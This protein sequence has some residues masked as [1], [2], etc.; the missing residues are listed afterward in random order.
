MCGIT[1]I[2]NYNLDPFVLRERALKMS[3]LL[4]H[5]GPDDAGIWSGPAV[6]LAHRRLSLLDT[7][8]GGQPM[9]SFNRRYSIVYNGEVYNFRE[10]RQE[11]GGFFETD[12]D[13]EVILRA[14]EKWGVSCLSR[15]NGMFSFFIWDSQ[16]MEG[17]AARDLLGVK[18]FLY[19]FE[20]EEFS[21]ASEAKALLAK[22]P[23]V[24]HEAIL[25]YLVAPC[26]S[27][28][29]QAPFRGIEVLPAGH[30][31]MISQKGVKV[32]QWG[33]CFDSIGSETNTPDLRKAIVKAVE[34]TMVADYP[35]CS[36]MS[37]GL[38]STL[39]SAIARPERCYSVQFEGHKRFDEESSQIVISDDLPFA[40]LAAEELGL[41]Q[42][43]VTVN[44]DSLRERLRRI[45]INNDLLPAWEQEVAQDALAA[46]ASREFK[47]VLVGDA[48]DETHYG[49]HFLLDA[50]SPAEM[51]ERVA[52]APIRRSLLDQP[53][54]YFSEKYQREVSNTTRLI[55]KRWLPR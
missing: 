16:K 30:F 50:S 28:V 13:T 4:A 7:R 53:V 12:C 33:D 22:A 49:Y 9:C 40:R 47:A 18:P 23:K 14:Y 15:L 32:S 41:K 38:D 10:L 31:L 52:F 55:V 2:V 43:V 8:N 17:F 46:A 44:D 42:E 21:F 45:S 51:L 48:A 3:A 34:R 39:I 5:R 1:G 35:V 11:I 19:R 27:G 26:F 24:N 20:D 37:G 25:E 54:E 29:S 36:Y 6:S